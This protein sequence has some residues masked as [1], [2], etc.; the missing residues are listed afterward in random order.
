M[1]DTIQIPVEYFIITTSDWTGFQIIE[2]GWWSDIEVKCL[3]G[4]D[5]LTKKIS[6]DER[7]VSFSKKAFDDTKVIVYV[8][9]ILNIIRAYLHSEIMYLITK[10]IIEKTDVQVVVAESEE[11]TLS[12]F[13]QDP[14]DWRNPYYF[15]IPV[16]RYVKALQKK[17]MVEKAKGKVKMKVK[18]KQEEP[19]VIITNF[20]QMFK[21]ILRKEEPTKKD[22]EAVFKWLRSNGEN[23]TKFIEAEICRNLTLQAQTH[24]WRFPNL[25]KKVGSE[26]NKTLKKIKKRFDELRKVEGKIAIQTPYGGIEKEQKKVAPNK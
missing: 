3:E 10:G 16:Q 6:F 5:S 18:A 13:K 4:C 9:C 21:E 15:S 25:K 22:V 11:Q 19:H 23:A 1:V 7:T 26:A 8:K 12:N 14:N 20:N 17:K 24:F 2:G